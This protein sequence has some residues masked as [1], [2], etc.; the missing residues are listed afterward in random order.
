[1]SLV[2]S[3]VNSDNYLLNLSGPLNINR[4]KDVVQSFRD[5][6]ER[7]VER[8]VVSLEDVPFIDSQGLAALIAGYKIFGSNPRNFQL[9][10]IQ[11]Q[12]KLVFEL[13]G[14]DRVFQTG[15]LSADDTT[16]AIALNLPAYGLSQIL[17]PDLAA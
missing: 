6:S 11:D 12:P 16:E 1:M 7:G 4:S 17:V 15:A 8:I 13:T 14:F 5:L 3:E 10:G 9:K 2:H